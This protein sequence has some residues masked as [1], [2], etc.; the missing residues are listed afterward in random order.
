MAVKRSFLWLYVGH[1]QEV[2]LQSW[3]FHRKMKN[4]I[5]KIEKRFTIMFFLTIF[6]SDKLKSIF[7]EDFSF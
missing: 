1:Q 5:E 2:W 7:I 4:R 6:G 3:K